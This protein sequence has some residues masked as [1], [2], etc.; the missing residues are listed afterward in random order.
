M[1]LDEP[2]KQN[3]SNSWVFVPNTFQKNDAS[4][5]YQLFDLFPNYY[6]LET[7]DFSFFKRDCNLLL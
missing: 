1:I 4:N 3:S 2:M 7:A 6:I 5:L